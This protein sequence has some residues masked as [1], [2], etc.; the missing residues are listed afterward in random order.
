MRCAAMRCRAMARRL[1]RALRRSPGLCNVALYAALFA[2]G[3][4]AQ[5][6]LGLGLGLGL[7]PGL[8]RRAGQAGADWAQ[9]RRVALVAL[10]FHGPFNYAWLRAL[11]RLLPGRAPAAVLAKVLCDQALGAPVAV[12]AFYTGLQKMTQPMMLS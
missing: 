11:E 3:D 7:G 4:A 10:A 8:R 12:L 6:Q 9:T 1:V 5:Q 2:A